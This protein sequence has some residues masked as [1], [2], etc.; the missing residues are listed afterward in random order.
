MA[1][2]KGQ[3]RRYD[4]ALRQEQA[5]QT[6][7]RILDA[8]QKLFSE[9]GYASTS[10]EAIAKGAGVATDTVYASFRTKPGLLHKLL[11][12]RV[13]GDDEP[14]G[15]L[16][17]E[18]PQAVRREPG[19]RRQIEAF[20]SDVTSIQDR[21]RPVDDIIRGAAAVDQEIAAFRTRMHE[22]RLANMRQF[23]S[24]VASKGPLRDGIS[25]DEAATIIW[26]LASPEVH[27]LLRAERGWTAE[28]Y[29]NWL[30]TTLTRTLLP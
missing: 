3:R 9:R 1:N 2:V 19:Q 6:R 5:R 27:R 8:A 26:T 23:A 14:V 7:A 20:A 18:G 28:R 22:A 12:V 17:R 13:G 10:M 30:A 21:A 4:S 24:W 25:V 15:L 29:R 11:D 16:D